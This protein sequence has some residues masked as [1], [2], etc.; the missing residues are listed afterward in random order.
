MSKEYEETLR[1]E[2]MFDKLSIYYD[3]KMHRMATIP[4]EIIGKLVADIV[5]SNNGEI[6]YAT[7]LF[8]NETKVSCRGH[9]IISQLNKLIPNFFINQDS[10]N[11]KE[12]YTIYFSSGTLKKERLQFAFKNT[13][14]PKLSWGD[15]IQ[16]IIKTQNNLPTTINL[17]FKITRETNSKL[18]KAKAVDELN[19]E[20]PEEY[21]RN[22]CSPGVS[23]KESYYTRAGRFSKFLGSINNYIARKNSQVTRVFLLE[24]LYGKKL[25]K[26]SSL[27]EFHDTLSSMPYDDF[28]IK[29][30]RK[31]KPLLR[32]L[33]GW[34]NGITGL[35]RDLQNVGL[36]PKSDLRR[37]ATVI[38]EAENLGHKTKVV[39]KKKVLVD[40]RAS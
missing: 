23:S 15:V 36:K 21:F 9:E 35:Y 1:Q 20:T 34:Y 16:Q 29:D 7:T 32:A 6:C 39:N 4:T 40:L 24:Y 14:N 30:V 28:S 19:A 17:D 27:K 13:W 25:P 26:N 31:M 38:K 5:V 18:R 22:A 33:E 11:E 10:N 3:S 2:K 8:H 12:D 37:W